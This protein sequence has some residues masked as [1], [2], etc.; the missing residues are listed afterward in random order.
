LYGSLCLLLIGALGARIS[1]MRGD[2]KSFIGDP[3][4]AELIRA[5]RA[6]GNATEYAPIQLVLLLAFELSG[7]GSVLL[8]VF[9]GGIVLARALHAT[10]VITKTPLSVA[11][12][13]LNY[14][15]CFG[16]AISGLVSHFR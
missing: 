3:P 11:G 12:A 2:K 5:V 7:T 4:D 13:S 8:H 1:K 6:H 14:L 9:G 10:G 16:M 15:V